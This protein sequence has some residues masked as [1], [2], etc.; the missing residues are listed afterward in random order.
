M[1]FI[2]PTKSG[3]YLNAKV[4][5]DEKLVGKIAVI[6]G[7]G[8]IDNFTSPEGKVKKVWNIPVEIEGRKKVFT[9][10]STNMDIMAKAWGSEKEGQKGIE[11]KDVVGK[12][13]KIN[14]IQVK[15][16]GQLVDSIQIEPVEKGPVVDGKK[17]EI[18]K[19]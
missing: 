16:K 18:V 7:E 13:F 6:A 15:Y 3:D 19:M 5:K 11:Q 12:M 10:N 17:V 2:I 4:V 8:T 14:L 9:P 1:S